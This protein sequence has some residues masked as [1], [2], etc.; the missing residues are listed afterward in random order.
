MRV[1]YPPMSPLQLLAVPQLTGSLEGGQ[2]HA[3]DGK[4][5]W[6]IFLSS[7]RSA[8]QTWT[9]WGVHCK[10]KNIS[11]QIEFKLDFFIINQK[12]RLFFQ[13][14][15]FRTKVMNN[16]HRKSIC[17]LCNSEGK[18]GIKN[19][20]R[21]RWNAVQEPS[22]RYLTVYKRVH[23]KIASLAWFSWPRSKWRTQEKCTPFMS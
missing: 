1:V 16:R 11:N 19:R 4:R 13:W 21:K 18:N 8:F 17:H 3:L 7:Q 12:M 10:K 2:G 20:F 15:S 5:P 9:N 6:F 23:C 14:L 22:F